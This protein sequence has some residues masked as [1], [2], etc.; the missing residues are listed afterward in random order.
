MVGKSFFSNNLKDNYNVRKGK[1]V[2]LKVNDGTFLI[3]KYYLYEKNGKNTDNGIFILDSHRLVCLP[4][5]F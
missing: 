4:F 1:N 5:F 3:L 2:Y